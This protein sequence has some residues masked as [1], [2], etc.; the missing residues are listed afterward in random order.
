MVGVT[1]DERFNNHT[2]W[3]WRAGLSF[4]YSDASGFVRGSSNARYWAVPVGINY[5]IGSRKNNLELGPGASLGIMNQ[6]VTE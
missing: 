2:H 4:A 3:G 5:L 6:H 1:Y